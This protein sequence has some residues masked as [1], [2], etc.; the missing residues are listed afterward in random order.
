MNKLVL[1]NNTFFALKDSNE[2]GTHYKNFYSNIKG[3]QMCMG[4][5]EP[6][7]KIEVKISENQEKDVDPIEYWGWIDNEDNYISLIYP[8]YFLLSMCF[9]YGIEATEKK[10]Q[11]KAIK[12]KLTKIE[13][14]VDTV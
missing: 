12:L 11:G 13:E 6:I 2:K 9:P 1:K 8:Q 14:Y 4:K 5:S 10:G 3:T 7:F